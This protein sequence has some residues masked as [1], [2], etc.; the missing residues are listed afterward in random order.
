M[1]QSA[2]AL[3]LHRAL[4]KVPFFDEDHQL[5]EPRSPN[6]YKFERFIFDLLPQAERSIVVEADERSAF[7]PVK[8]APGEPKDTPESVQA[9]MI[10]LHSAWLRDAGAQ[11]A[12]N[13][14]VEIRPT[15]ALDAVELREKLQ[16][17]LVVSR[18]TVFA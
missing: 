5:I 3:P 12:E 4:K 10:A 1:S 14:A 7:A 17:G 9:Q 13:V 15:F 6:A 8:N 18:P 2:A 11:L 16:P